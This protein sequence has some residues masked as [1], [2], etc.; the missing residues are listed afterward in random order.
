MTDVKE[1]RVRW[2]LLVVECFCLTFAS[3][4]RRLGGF[5]GSFL[6]LLLG[7]PG[8]ELLDSD[9]SLTGVE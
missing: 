7:V 9:K 6:N 2:P 3:Q 4:V 8:R 1:L 5:D